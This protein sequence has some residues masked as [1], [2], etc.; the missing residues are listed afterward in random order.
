M[1]LVELEEAIEAAR[2]LGATDETEI[3]IS[4]IDF[5]E[6][7]DTREQLFATFERFEG[8]PGF[9]WINEVGTDVIPTETEL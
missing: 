5:T 3:G 2:V 6:N 7:N 4:F 8:G 1:K 9:L